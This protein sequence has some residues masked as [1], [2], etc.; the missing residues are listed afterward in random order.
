MRSS[1]WPFVIMVV[2]GLVAMADLSDTLKKKTCPQNV[3]CMHL[4]ERLFQSRLKAFSAGKV[5]ST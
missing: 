2:K 4:A 3:I 5:Q 1:P